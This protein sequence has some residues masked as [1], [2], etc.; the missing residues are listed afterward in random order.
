MTQ[1]AHANDTLIAPATRSAAGRLHFVDHLRASIIVLVI[2]LHTS[3]TYMAYAP[4]W[5][6]VVE[7]ENSMVFTTLVLALDVPNMQILFFISGFFAYAS[8]ERTGTAR[9]MRQKLVRIG[10]PWIVG[11]VFLAP[12]VTYLIPVTRGIA[13]PYLQFWTEEF[14]GPYYQQSV[15][16]FLGVLLLLFT[17]LALAYLVLPQLRGIPRE[18]QEPTRGLLIAFWGLTSLWYFIVSLA[19][20]ADTWL[21][22]WK[23]IVYQPARLMLYAGYFVLGIVAD[24]RGWFRAGGFQPD[25]GTWA[26]AMAASAIGYLGVRLIW[27]Q[28][29]ALFLAAQAALF[30]AFCL[31]ALLA[32]MAFFERYVN[33]PTPVWTSLSRNAYAIY[34]L[35]PLV[36]YPA[37]YLALSLQAP[38]ALEVV[39]LTVFTTLVCWAV[40][41]LILTRW[42]V[43]RDIF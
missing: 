42:P 32:G 24:R 12:L 37:A 15:Y 34:Y 16:W 17:L 38:I 11:V 30:N 29:G 19:L 4:E 23:L 27:V 8:L 40:G 18:P 35:H 1:Y 31:T 22:A 14:W 21:N 36:L 28:G 26:P 39:G 43:L 3:M 9:F 5:W 13:I 41:A 33:N 6:Y 7:P 25:L 10:L 20:P 2:L